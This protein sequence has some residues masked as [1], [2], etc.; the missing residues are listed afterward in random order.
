MRTLIIIF[1]LLPLVGLA[2]EV[3]IAVG[4]SSES[5]AVTIKQHSG[6]DITSGLEIVGPKGEHPLA[7]ICWQF[8]DY[9]A[10]IQ[11][12]VRDGTVA[13]LAYWTKKDFSESKIHRA[14]TEQSITALKL[15]T[16][17]RGV[18]IEK[19]KDAG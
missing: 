7:G 4:Q 17:T 15:D 3:R 9:D 8:E 1:L 14:K 2:D 12:S 6:K 19:K 10:V 13:H 11:L 18:S 16:K 5:V